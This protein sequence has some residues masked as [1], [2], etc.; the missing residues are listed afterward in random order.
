MSH[1]LFFGIRPPA[2][3]R[4]ALLDLMSGVDNARWQDDDQLH[5][6]L[7]FIGEVETHRA[8][9]IA[10]AAHEIRF[11]PFELY[12][13]GCGFFERKGT[14]TILYAS[15]APSEQLTRLQ[16]KVER[17]CVKSGVAAETRK[18]VPHLTLAR[19]NT[20]SGSIAPFLARNGDIAL[21]PWTVEDFTLYEAT[22]RPQGSLY[23]PIVT[24]TATAR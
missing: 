15:V 8:D 3:I 13:A 10:E 7:R 9:D 24:Y 19:L 14:P 4:N 16:R 22:L 1:R 21:A 6:T 2:D 11:D 5:L 20:G 18:F 12:V 17:I 23:D